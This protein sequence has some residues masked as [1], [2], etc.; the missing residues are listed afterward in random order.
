M[1]SSVYING[2]GASGAAAA[3]V[4]MDD[5][6]ADALDRALA[7]C[8]QALQTLDGI[9]A[10]GN[11]ADD[12][13]LSPL[14]R[15]EATG[16]VGREYTYVT[17]SF[18]QAVT[19]AAA[20]IASGLSR[21][22]AVVGWGSGG[23]APD[24]NEQMIAEPFFLRPV[25]ATP[26]NLRALRALA[27]GHEGRI[28][29]QRAPRE[30]AAVCLVMGAEPAGAGLELAD[31]ASGFHRYLPAPDHLD[32]DRWIAD[33]VPAGAEKVV[34]AAGESPRPVS[35][36]MQG[37]VALHTCLGER[38]AGNGRRDFWFVESAGPLGQSL[39]A[40]RLVAA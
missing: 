8:G 1:S 13:L 5:L 30:D 34:V 31:W 11:D 25:G 19:T 12:G 26:D 14:L 22:L 27:L 18:C 24:E 23:D 28:E 4:P 17:G 35:R 39:T 33:L 7:G 15:A 3:T 36:W 20:L 10:C 32:P 40:L 2:C 9:V 16:A 21:R 38:S 6:I 37:A 29:P